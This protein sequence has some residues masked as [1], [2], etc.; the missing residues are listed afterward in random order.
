MVVED[1]KYSRTYI[2][3][4]YEQNCWFCNKEYISVHGM[5]NVKPITLSRT[6]KHLCIYNAHGLSSVALDTSA[7]YTAY[8]CWNSVPL[9]WRPWPITRFHDCNSVRCTAVQFHAILITSQLKGVGTFHRG[10]RSRS[11]FGPVA[12]VDR[13]SQSLG[14]STVWFQLIGRCL[15]STALASLLSSSLNSQ[16][17]LVIYLMAWLTTFFIKFRASRVGKVTV[18]PVLN[19]S[20]INSMALTL[21]HVN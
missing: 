11:W 15:T 8:Q 5:N 7:F 9:L 19:C 4:A 20:A 16:D 13:P 10:A 18:S 12:S 2:I 14:G 1:R 17:D 21:L 3:I 6:I